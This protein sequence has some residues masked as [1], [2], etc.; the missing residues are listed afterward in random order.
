MTSLPWLN[1]R[2]IEALQHLATSNPSLYQ[3]LKSLSEQVSDDLLLKVYDDE[4]FRNIPP[5]TMAKMNKLT[6]L[7]LR[8][9]SWSYMSNADLKKLE[10]EMTSIKNELGVAGVT[11]EVREM[12]IKKKQANFQ[13]MIDTIKNLG[14]IFSKMRADWRI[15]EPE[16]M[17][18][19]IFLSVKFI[20]IIS[21]VQ[22]TNVSWIYNIYWKSFTLALFKL[23]NHDIRLLIN[24][25]SDP[26]QVDSFNEHLDKLDKANFRKKLP[27]LWRS[28]ATWVSFWS[29]QWD[30][31]T[32]E[33]DTYNMTL[34]NLF[35]DPRLKETFAALAVITSHLDIQEGNELQSPDSRVEFVDI[36]SWPTIIEIAADRSKK[37]GKNLSW[38][39]RWLPKIVKIWVPVTI[40]LLWIIYQLSQSSKG[41]IY[42]A[43][44]EWDLEQ[45][46]VTL[47]PEAV[48]KLSNLYTRQDSARVIFANWR[49]PSLNEMREYFAG[50]DE[51]LSDD[52]RTEWANALIAM[53]EKLWYQSATTSNWVRNLKKWW[54]WVKTVLPKWNISD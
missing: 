25:L 54:Q 19:K 22:Q 14:G 29:S 45:Q 17:Q 13:W 12:V 18:G 31:I 50:S 51:L 53:N 46:I 39:I 48:S 8:K 44:S 23:I 27:T 33:L 36:K 3:Q 40:L 32:I 5:W 2:D 20:E 42:T 49:N 34:K 4:K 35:S 30:T 15:D 21:V 10:E 41:D 37:I 43:L 24:F 38:L 28:N 1:N 47:D 6:E 26:K 7:L 52:E 9:N 11:Q 16:A